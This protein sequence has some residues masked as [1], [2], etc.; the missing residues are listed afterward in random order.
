MQDVVYFDDNDH[1]DSD[2]ILY[3]FGCVKQ[4]THLFKS[5]KVDGILGL[6]NQP[7]DSAGNLF[8][9]IFR[10]MYKAGKI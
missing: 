3:N 7:F 8:E 9:P 4:E 2:G 10:T 1:A 6:S 5:Q